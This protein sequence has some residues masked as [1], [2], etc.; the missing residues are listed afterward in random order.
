MICQ[1]CGT[2]PRDWEKDS[3]AYTAVLIRCQGCR[4]RSIR[5][6]EVPEGEEGIK[7]PLIPTEIAMAMHE[8]NM[9][10]QRQQPMRERPTE[11]ANSFA[12][13]G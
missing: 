7:V 9:A 2:D 5:Y 6:K 3:E 13:Y 8:A 4:E 12:T 11:S 10:R 1:E